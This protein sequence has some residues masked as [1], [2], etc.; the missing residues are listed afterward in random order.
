MFL[1]LASGYWFVVV[2]LFFVFFFLKMEKYVCTLIGEMVFR[3]HR[4]G[5]NDTTR[6]CIENIRT[7]SSYYDDKYL[8]LVN[9]VCLTRCSAIAVQYI[10]TQLH[11]SVLQTSAPPTVSQ[12]SIKSVYTYLIIKIILLLYIIMNVVII[13][14]ELMK[15][16]KEI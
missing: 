12:V 8:Y 5:L 11:P 7:S 1:C 6:R 10:N 4:E 3:F 16:D 14:R 13:L 9:N 2:F 15:I